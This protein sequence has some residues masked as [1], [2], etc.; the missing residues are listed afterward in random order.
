M[1]GKDGVVEWNVFDVFVGHF[2]E[3][4]VSLADQTSYTC[5]LAVS[6]NQLS[7]S[8]RR[9]TK[10]LSQLPSQSILFLGLFDNISLENLFFLWRGISNDLDTFEAV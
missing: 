9:K 1:V 6:L 2:L 4:L 8:F 10:F 5:L 3:Y 7:D